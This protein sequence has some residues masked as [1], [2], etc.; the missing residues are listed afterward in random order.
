MRGYDDDRNTKV[1]ISIALI[2]GLILGAGFNGLIGAI[3]PESGQMNILSVPDNIGVGKSTI[4]K[5]ITFSN[6][7]AV[8]NVNITLSGAAVSYGKTDENGML[9]LP[10]YATTNGSIGV[11]ASRSG[12]RNGT[13][14]IKATPGLDVSAIPSSI[15]SG[16]TTYVTFTV[17]SM[18]K[19][20]SGIYVNISGDGIAFEGLTDPSGQVIKQINAPNTG[21]IYATA[22]K[23]G[24]ADGSAVVTSV[25]QQILTVYSTHSS[26]TVNV[27]VY[28]ALTVTSGGSPIADAV[29]SI[30]G[31][32]TGDGIT[33]QDG[34]T[35]ILLTP[36]TTGT[37]TASAS[38][39]GFAGGHIT[40]TST[41]TQ[42]LSVS[43]SPSSITAGNPTFVTF[44]VKSGNSFISD[45]TVTLTGAASGNAVT[46]QNGIAIIHVNST[47][48]GTITAT[49]SLKGYTVGTTTFAAVGQQTISV[50]A[51][52]SN[53]TNGAATFVTFTVKSGSNP[54]S[55][56]TVSVSGGG[57]TEDGM[58]NTAG[59][60]TMQ[61]TASGAV[62]INVVARKDGYTDAQMTLGH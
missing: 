25:S 22:R 6:G 2:G 42:S 20:V 21:K 13:S 33:N 38:K 30:S 32:A 54:V 37:I 46:N 11:T 18:G 12:Y 8:G 31:A 39:T 26:L 9:E 60:V 58:T 1:Y 35:I 48:A 45:S 62:A 47:G 27:P 43:A 36:H 7:A 61:L 17:K 23:D 24:Y 50:S 44:T 28:V 19:P 53:L 55:G 10:V 57:I 52:P 15:T 59:Q 49:A 56:A 3:L 51:S 29:I 34:K 4:V 5:L 40:I 41:G 14:V 16:V